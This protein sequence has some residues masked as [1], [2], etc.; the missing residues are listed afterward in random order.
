[1]VW[2]CQKTLPLNN[3]GNCRFEV[4][5]HGRSF[6][7]VSAKPSPIVKLGKS[8][9][10]G[11]KSNVWWNVSQKSPTI[12]DLKII[13]CWKEDRSSKLSAVS[14]WCGLARSLLPMVLRHPIA[15]CQALKIAWWWH[16]SKLS[17]L[18]SKRTVPN[19]VA[20][21]TVCHIIG[22]FKGDTSSRCQSD[23]AWQGHSFRWFW[24]TLSP[25]I[26][27]WKWSGRARKRYLWTTEGTA[28]L[29]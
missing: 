24:K 7:W 9:G 14:V 20:M 26:K 6:P 3:W 17:W 16:K 28:A 5:W 11:T 27:V 21:K 12:V 8:C 13:G 19:N 22:C 23:A 10:D 29:K 2:S 15:K 1:M 18:L 25:K 4:V